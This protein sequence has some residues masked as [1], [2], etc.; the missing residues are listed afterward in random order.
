MKEEK[1]HNIL[2]EDIFKDID[3]RESI[4]EDEVSKKL[5]EM[6]FL[7]DRVNKKLSDDGTCFDC[8]AKVDIEKGTHQLVE[9]TKVEE[10][11]VAFVLLCQECIE[12]IRTKEEPKK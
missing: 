7:W 4:D 12:K 9:A 3:Q 1:N 6:G 2:E 10:G 8:K 5:G 11:V